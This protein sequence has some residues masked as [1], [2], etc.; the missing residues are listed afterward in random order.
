MGNRAVI[1]FENKPDAVGVYVHWNGGVESV[2]AFCHAAKSMGA[3]S[4]NGDNTYAMAGLIR[5]IT[6]FMHYNPG[7]L[8]SMGVGT[9]GGLDCDNY[10]NGLFIID[11]DWNIKERLY[12]HDSAMSVDDLSDTAHEN[13]PSQKQ[14]Y[15]GIMTQILERHLHICEEAA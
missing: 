4:P 12:N 2:L 9:V 15:L 14:Q 13:W 7:E 10:D 11:G 8:L 6:L 3:R 5:A 1:A